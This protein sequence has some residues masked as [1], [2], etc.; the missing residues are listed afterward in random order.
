VRVVGLEPG[1]VHVGVRVHEVAVAVLVRVLRVRVVVP[2]VGVAVG[3][4][5]VTVL[6]GVSAV[7]VVLV[8]VGVVRHGGLLGL[9]GRCGSDSTPCAPSA[10]GT[11]GPATI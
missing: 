11:G 1:L 5:A 8:G 6:V 3:D 4:V 2:G 10:P 9:E 7:V